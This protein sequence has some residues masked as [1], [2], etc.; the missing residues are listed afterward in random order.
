MATRRLD[1]AIIFCV[2][3]FVW[4]VIKRFLAKYRLRGNQNTTN[5]CKKSVKPIEINHQPF[6]HAAQKCKHIPIL[7]CINDAFAC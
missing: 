3:D 1:S 2:V 6:G 7:F 4:E 5:C